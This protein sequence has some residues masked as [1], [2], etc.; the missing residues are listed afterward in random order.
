[1]LK[2]S[3]VLLLVVLS[4]FMFSS[5]VFSE[6]GPECGCEA[7]VEKIKSETEKE[8]EKILEDDVVI[9]TTCPVMGGEVKPDTEYKIKYNGKVI[10]FCCEGCIPEFK[11]DPEKYIKKITINE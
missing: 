5:F 6:C 2:K 1:M 7:C 9:N 3:Y 8:S 4:V 11:K 10:G